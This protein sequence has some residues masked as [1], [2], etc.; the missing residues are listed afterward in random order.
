MVTAL[1]AAG[2]DYVWYVDDDDW[3]ASGSI[4]AIKDAVHALDRPILIGASE[5]VEEEWD[6]EALTNST[7]IRRYLPDEWYRGFTGWNFL[8]NCSM[9]IPRHL[10]LQRLGDVPI[11]RDHG[12]DY[13]LQLLLL[14]APGS[15][16]QVMNHTIAHISRRTD[17]DNAV[18]MDDRVPWLR[19]LGSHIS[20]LSHDASASTAA[21]WR[22]GSEARKIPYPETTSGPEDSVADADPPPIPPSPIA[23]DLRGWLR[24]TT[25]RIRWLGGQDP[26]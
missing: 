18:T 14:T 7:S 8:P 5:V 24:A 23:S 1:K 21:F 19:D 25:D 26:R 17:G 15:M 6:G 22:L 12:E 13:A 3:V 2:G 4:Q 9:V 11:I 20:D 10:A 16:V